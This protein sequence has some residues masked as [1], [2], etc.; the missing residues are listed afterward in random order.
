MSRALRAYSGCLQEQA[1][2]FVHSIRLHGNGQITLSSRFAIDLHEILP[3]FTVTLVTRQA[4][5]AQHWQLLLR[6][7]ESSECQH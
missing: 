5:N 1:F 7:H 3:P 2:S 6:P 4:A